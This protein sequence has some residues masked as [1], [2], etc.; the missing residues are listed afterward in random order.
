MSFFFCNFAAEMYVLMNYKTL[1]VCLM[2]ALAQ[3]LCAGM[4]QA[5]EAGT[6]VFSVSATKT[7]RFANANSIYRDTALIQWKNLEAAIDAGWDVLT[8][9]EW[10]YLLVTRDGE[11]TSKNALGTVDGQKGLVI[12]PDEWSQPDG[13]TYAATPVAYET[14]VYTAE[15]WALMANAGAVFLPCGGYGYKDG[16]GYHVEDPT[17]HG[18]YWAKDEVSSG[19]ANA[20]CMRFNVSN[21]HDLNNAVKTN[22]YSVILVRDA[23]I[24]EL[25]EQDD[26]DTYFSKWNA[27]KG[28]DFAYVKRTLKKDSTLYTLCLPFDVP[29][30]EDSPL[31]GAEVFEFKGGRVSGTTGNERLFLQLSRLNGKRLTQGVPYLLRWA[32][33]SPVETLPSPLYFANVENWDTDTT[34]AAHP[35]NE[36]IKLRGVYPTTHIPDYTSDPVVPHYNFF[37]GANN[38]LYWPDKTH[39]PDSDM[40]GFRAYFYIIPPAPDPADAPRYRNMPVVWQIGDGLSSP[41]DIGQWTLD[42]G[43]TKQLRNGQIILVIDGKEFDLQGKQLK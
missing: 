28:K 18:A 20:Y 17:D 31:A 34:T 26:A 30:I 14:N 27:A 15:K 2:I 25:D 1:Y 12:L 6:G 10:T 23:S 19:S 5:T 11:G 9:D 36:T 4:M 22:Y 32:K 7:V 42:N 16:S 29:D 3:V 39:Y 37:L 21:I 33:T 43:W 8:S 13:T 41:T 40:K 35:G 24:T 38:T